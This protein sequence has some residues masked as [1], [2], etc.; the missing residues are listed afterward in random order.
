MEV[1]KL[2][3]VVEAIDAFLARHGMA[4]TRFG[5]EA[6]RD[7]NLVND[8]RR[9]RRSPRL[10]LLHK[11]KAFMDAR[12]AELAIASPHTDTDTAGGAAMSPDSAGDPIGEAV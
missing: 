8:L 4:H 6:T 2:E 7:A 5:S 10:D 1:P 3:D 9:G 12:D 11:I